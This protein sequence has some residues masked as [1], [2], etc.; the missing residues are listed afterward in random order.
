MGRR[1]SSASLLPPLVALLPSACSPHPQVT[2][3]SA[4]PPLVCPG[5][6]AVVHWDVRGRAS[7]RAER[8][9]TDWDEQAVPSQ[10]SRTVV[11]AVTTT[12]K[13]TALDANPADG[14]AY[15]TKLVQIP[16][17]GEVRAVAAPCD[18][19][20]RKCRGS[21]TLDNGA[22]PMVAV[23]LSAPIRVQRGKEGPAKICVAHDGL[24]SETCVPAGG[25]VAIGPSV[26]AQGAW[27]LES[28]LGADDA[29]EPPPQLRIH[30][31]FG[32][33]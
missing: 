7:L 9:A 2:S 24:P 19:A 4:L 12:F 20:S 31:D 21:F 32:C 1:S 11:P 15:G 26:S 33:P 23:T 10:G 16:R 30:F 22:G 8:G 28:E 29:L 25:A 13:I 27:T 3:F 17:P 14:N 6:T 5:Q 18:A